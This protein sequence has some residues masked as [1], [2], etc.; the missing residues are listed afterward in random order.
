MIR[1]DKPASKLIQV[2]R[3]WRSYREKPVSA[4]AKESIQAF[5]SGLYDPP[6]G[7]TIRF[8]IAEAELSGAKRPQG[9][10]GVVKGASTFLVGILQPSTKGLEDFG[11]LFEAVVLFITSLGLGTCWMGGT[12]DRRLFSGMT[13]IQEGEIIPAISPIGIIAD[14]RTF[15]DSIFSMTAG[16]RTRKP[17]TEIFFQE[18]F[19]NTLD[20][21]ATDVYAPPLEMLRLA[22]SSS[23]KQPWRIV[24]KNRCFHFYLL[25]TRGYTA[26]FREV[27]LQRI[28]MGIAMFHFEQT[29]RESGLP[30]RWEDHDPGI[31]GLPE[32]TEYVISWIP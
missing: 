9:T 17:W 1:Y 26:I 25:R 14:R 31:S 18:T 13:Q 22:P 19:G 20:R 7:S 8:V 6:F 10:Y 3:S 21:D 30:G 32:R 16:S 12:F 29:A 27:D 24:M 23:N 28:D 15:V 11:Y 4:D 2:R 5:I